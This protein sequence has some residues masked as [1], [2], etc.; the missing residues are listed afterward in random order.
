MAR[1]PRTGATDRAGAR[2]ICNPLC[3]RTVLLSQLAN[4]ANNGA[5]SVFSSALLRL[6]VRETTLNMKPD[7]EAPASGPR[8]GCL[9]S[10]L[11]GAAAPIGAAE[12]GRCVGDRPW[13]APRE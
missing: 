8:E 12:R 10:G 3:Y 7:R 4:H 1:L 9:H 13:A 5:W 6:R 11:P 2:R